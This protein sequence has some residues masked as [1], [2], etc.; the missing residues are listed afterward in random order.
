M[1]QAVK[2]N[3]HQKTA[4]FCSQIV[5]RKERIPIA[6][7]KINRIKPFDAQLEQSISF[8]WNGNQAYGNRIAIYEKETLAKVYDNTIETFSYEHTLSPASL[9]NGKCYMIQCQVYD[10]EG[11]ESAWSD[12]YYFYTL[13]TPE[14]SFREIPDVVRASSFQASITYYQESFENL[15]SYK[16]A[17][18]DSAKML[19]L[20]TD[21]MYDPE[22]L[23]YSFKGLENDTIYYIRCFGVTFHGMEVDT[24][25]ERIFVAYEAPGVYSRIYAECDSDNGC[26]SYFTNIVII[27]P[28]PESD[29]DFTF[30]DG[31]INLIGKKLIYDEGFCIEDDFTLKV[32]GTDLYRSGDVITLKNKD[33]TLKITA[34][35]SPSGQIRYKLIVPN[36]VS[37]YIQYSNPLSGSSKDNI[38]I[39]LRRI[40]QIYEIKAYKEGG[41]TL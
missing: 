36:A 10:V 19:L 40:H 25:Y 1:R 12:K 33:T 18:Y 3:L 32:N 5:L 39:V 22:D 23:S 28:S 30:E 15:L 4:L 9:E 35:L 24:G 26:V 2:E 7:P 31:K 13:K 11:I 21:T 27:K 6:K 20:E 34:V 14:F 8:T 17:I 38:T 29:M 16:F 41:G 37:Q